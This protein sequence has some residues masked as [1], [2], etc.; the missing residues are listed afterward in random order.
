MPTSTEPDV[1]KMGATQLWVMLGSSI[2]VIMGLVAVLWS[3]L[4]DRVKKC[5]SSLETGGQTF[6]DMKVLMQDIKTTQDGI[7]KAVSKN[8]INIERINSGLIEV[9]TRQKDCDSCP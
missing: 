1:I 3:L 8:E 6:E 9:Q 2:T 7:T 5:E 4:T